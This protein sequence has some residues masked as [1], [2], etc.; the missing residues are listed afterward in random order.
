MCSVFRRPSIL[1]YILVCALP[2]LIIVLVAIE[3]SEVN[4]D[5]YVKELVCVGFPGSPRRPLKYLSTLK[6]HAQAKVIKNR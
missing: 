5:Y 6:G 2:C 4:G 1:M 3:N